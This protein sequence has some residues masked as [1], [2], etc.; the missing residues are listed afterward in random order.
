MRFMNDYDLEQARRRFTGENMP[1]RLALT[2]VVDNLREQTD[3]VSDGWAY[4]S[5]PA[6]SAASAMALIDSSTFRETE[7]IDEATMLRAVMPI[8]AMLTRNRG[9]F[10]A[11]QREIILRAVTS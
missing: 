2:M 5:K 1:N 6:N 4:W 8:K 3:L 11:E 7:D 9:V 10:S